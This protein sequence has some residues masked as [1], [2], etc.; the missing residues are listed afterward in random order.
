M[1]LLNILSELV[2]I[3]SSYPQEEKISKYM[4]SKLKKMGFEVRI[5]EVE[6]KRVNILAEKGKGRAL[7]LCGH[8]DTI[9]KKK[10]WDT[11]PYALTQRGDKLFGLGAWDMKA[12]IAA[13]LS[14]VDQ[15]NPSYKLKLAFVVDEEF[16]SLGMHTLIKSGWLSDVKA[17]I[18]PEPGFDF[19][20]KG[21]SI[22]RIGRSVYK[23]IV[24]TKGGH[25]YLAKSRINAINEAYKVVNLIG[26]IK[27][28]KHKNLGESFLFVRSIRGGGSSMSIPNEV[29]IEIEAQLV[30]PQTTQ[31]VLKDLKKVLD[32]SNLNAKITIEPLPRQTP[33][34]EPYILDTKNSFVK[35]V[36]QVL[37]GVTGEKP[38]LYYRRSVGDENRVAQLGIPVITVGPD[39]GNAHEANEWVSKKG[40]SNLEKFFKD[41]LASGSNL[42]Q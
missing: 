29:E 21:I 27:K 13:I 37:T 19:G 4:V 12:G 14:A 6:G 9:E 16:I 30:P 15:F 35:K 17:A 38:K 23:V 5:Q 40:I 42:V 41:L 20:V 25:T 22:G 10:D 2:S 34:C 24:E 36:S 7:L 1:K 8:M 31:S 32:D 18:I 11:N 26:K 33:F 39:G 3:P 28:I